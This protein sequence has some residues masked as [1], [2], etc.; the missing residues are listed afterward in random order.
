LTPEEAKAIREA[1]RRLNEYVRSE[2]SETL[3]GAG[4]SNTSEEDKVPEELLPALNYLRDNLDT[5]IAVALEEAG[6][7]NVSEYFRRLKLE[8]KAEVFTKVL[9]R[10]FGFVKVPP[11]NFG[12]EWEVYVVSD[13]NVLHELD[14]VLEPATGFLVSRGWA[15][16]TIKRELEY[17]VHDIAVPIDYRQIDPWGYLRLRRGVLDL[18]ELKLLDHVPTTLGVGSA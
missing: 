5:L 9:G 8:E 10:V 7:G 1:I 11:A 4:T 17:S 15:R 18:R 12:E 13:G 2:D 16:S 14:T 6:Y 3:V